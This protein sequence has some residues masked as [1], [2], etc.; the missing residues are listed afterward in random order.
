MATETIGRHPME[1]TLLRPGLL[2]AALARTVAQEVKFPPRLASWSIPAAANCTC[3]N[4]NAKRANAFLDQ[5]LRE[6]TGLSL[7]P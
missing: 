1:A 7:P 3:W 4:R 2:L 5:M 6:E